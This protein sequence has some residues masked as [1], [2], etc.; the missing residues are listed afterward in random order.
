MVQISIYKLQYWT[1]VNNIPFKSHIEIPN[2]R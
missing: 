1:F 2:N